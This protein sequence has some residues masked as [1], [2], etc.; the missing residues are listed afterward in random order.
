QRPPKRIAGKDGPTRNQQQHYRRRQQAA[1]QVIEN[2]PTRDCRDAIRLLL[3][4]R[5]ARASREPTGNLP[6]APRPTMLAHRIAVVMG[7]VI[8]E[9]LYVADQCRAGKDRLEQIV[10]QKRL[11]GRSV[12]ERL[13]ESIDGIQAFARVDA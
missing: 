5:V 11:F 13:L 7:R 3:S 4:L 10:A 1:S 6:V 8:V 9:K 12:I 2:F